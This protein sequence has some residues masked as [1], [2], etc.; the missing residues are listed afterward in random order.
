MGAS[1]VGTGKAPQP[2]LNSVVSGQFSVTNSQGGYE[3]VLSIEPAFPQ[4]LKTTLIL[5]HL[6]HPS[7]SLRAGLKVVP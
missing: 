6:W 4:G 5:L 1:F 7:A 3:Q 2:Y